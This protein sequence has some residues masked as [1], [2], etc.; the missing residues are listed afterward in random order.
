M[1]VEQAVDDI[2]TRGVSELRK[3]A[4][5]DDADDAKNL[6]WLREQAW[7]IMK[8]LSK[9]NEIPYHEVLIEFPFKGD[10]SSLR[11]MEH[12]ELI[13]INTQNG[14]RQR[15][16][17]RFRGAKISLRPTFVDQAG[18]ACVPL[19]LREARPWFVYLF[20]TGA[21]PNSTIYRPD[22][23][24]QSRNSIQPKSYCSE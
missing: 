17:W 2:I 12:A 10:E 16:I 19:C 8:Q 1:T 13:A 20:I 23:P 15:S 18:K 11:E 5:G 21:S 14:E 9:H 3:S 22:L 4:F 24:G 6:P 7:A